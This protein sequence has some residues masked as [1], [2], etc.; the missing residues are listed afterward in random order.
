MKSAR[1]DGEEQPESAQDQA[2]RRENDASEQCEIAGRRGRSA[3]DPRVRT[4]RKEYS[5]SRPYPVC[6]KGES[7]PPKKRIAAGTTP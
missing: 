2:Q 4:R 3:R 1:P 5:G 6:G 7:H